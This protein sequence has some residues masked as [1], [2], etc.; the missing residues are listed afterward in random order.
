MNCFGFSNLIV[1]DRGHVKEFFDAPEDHVSFTTAY[2]DGF[3][4][5]YLF[6]SNPRDSY[7]NRAIRGPMT[8]NLNANTPEI[9]NEVNAALD[10][11]LGPIVTKDRTEIIFFYLM[12]EYTP[13][14][15]YEKV[16]RIIARLS[17]RV[18]VGLP[19][20]TYNSY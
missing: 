1:V 19:T 8:H 12:V 18:I 6:R 17:S 10:D 11:E 5:D 7:H 2:F 14:G 13:I 9:A 16:E 3:S 20:C 15:L 4:V